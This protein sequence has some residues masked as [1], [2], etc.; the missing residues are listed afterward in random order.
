MR[1]Q[2]RLLKIE[3]LNQLLKSLPLL[4][5]HDQFTGPDLE[6]P[7]ALVFHFKWT[8]QMGKRS[9]QFYDFR[10][11][12]AVQKVKFVELCRKYGWSDRGNARRALQRLSEWSPAD[13]AEMTGLLDAAAESH[14]ARMAR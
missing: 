3:E 6:I 4:G 14:V 10:H 5:P 2:L 11:L 7:D 13:R 1:A 8:E 12:K 9:Y